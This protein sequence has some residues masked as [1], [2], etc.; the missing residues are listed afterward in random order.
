MVVSRSLRNRSRYNGGRPGKRST[1]P[2]LKSS[3]ECSANLECTWNSK[4]SKCRKIPAKRVSKTAAAARKATRKPISHILAWVEKKNISPE[5]RAEL[6][7]VKTLSDLNNYDIVENEIDGN[8]GYRNAGKYIYKDNGLYNLAVHIDDY[9]HLP[10]WVEV[11]KEDCGHSYFVE[12]YLNLIDHNTLIPFITNEWKIGKSHV[13]DEDSE[14][15]FN[16]AYKIIDVITELIRKKDGAKAELTVV[17][18]LS[19]P[20]LGGPTNDIFT[21]NLHDLEDN[22]SK[23]VISQNDLKQAESKANS[24]LKKIF[25]TT[26]V[27]N[28]DCEAPCKFRL[29]TYPKYNRSQIVILKK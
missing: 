28:P 6:A 22:T 27:I 4:F 15:S 1:C 17:I 18:I 19:A 14:L 3:D 7:G 25:K 29:G 23:V 5:Q 21:D 16:G 13:L 8:Y 11:N 10:D 12:S 2:S 9:G 24:F 26:K 20:W